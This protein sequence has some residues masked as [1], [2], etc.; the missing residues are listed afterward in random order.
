M[1]ADANAALL[2]RSQRNPIHTARDWPY[3]VNTVFNPGAVTKYFYDSRGGLT[4]VTADYGTG[5]AK[6]TPASER[7]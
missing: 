7:P 1:S 6:D 2:V 3:P 5:N 4:K